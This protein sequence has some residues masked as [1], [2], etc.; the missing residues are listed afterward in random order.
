VL[1]DFPDFLVNRLLTISIKVNVPSSAESHLEERG[2]KMKKT[3]TRGFWSWLG[4]SG[5][6]SGGGNG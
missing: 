6:A 5:W 4:G 3:Q 1:D 2:R